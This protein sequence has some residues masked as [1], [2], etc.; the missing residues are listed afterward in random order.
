MN[1]VLTLGSSKGRGTRA[2]ARFDDLIRD[3]G[4][5]LISSIILKDGIAG[6]AN[7]GVEYTSLM[8]GYDAST[9]VS[10]K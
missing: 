9:W 3:R 7:T 1:S 2:A 5:G 8:E 4:V 10:Q 6:W